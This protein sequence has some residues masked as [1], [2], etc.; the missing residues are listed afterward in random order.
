MDKTS[1][2]AVF[3]ASSPKRLCMHSFLYLKKR[4]APDFKGHLQVSRRTV[5]LCSPGRRQ[6][7]LG[8]ESTAHQQL[9]RQKASFPALLTIW[10]P[11]AYILYIVIPRNHLH[12]LFRVYP[13]WG[14]RPRR[15]SP[16]HLPSYTDTPPVALPI[17]PFSPISCAEPLILWLEL[18]STCHD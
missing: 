8:T 9:L 16:A 1:H 15:P 5:S 12:F 18:L 17:T 10:P 13:L 7:N 2:G 14:P 11:D 6:G 3:M 4:S